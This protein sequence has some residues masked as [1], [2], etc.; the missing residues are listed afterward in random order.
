[1]HPTTLPYVSL[2][3]WRGCGYA[4]LFTDLQ[5]TH[6]ERHGQDV[7]HLL[8]NMQLRLIAEETSGGQYFRK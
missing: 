6:V 8:T 4:R 3:L 7:L 1:M 5:F 2:A